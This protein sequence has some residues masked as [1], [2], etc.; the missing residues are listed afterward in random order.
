[1]DWGCRQQRVAKQRKSRK[2]D[3]ASVGLT[4]PQ[5]GIT[6]SFELEIDRISVSKLT[7]KN[8]SNA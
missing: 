2:V 5:H 4:R 7:I 8:T 1:M 6:F 3:S